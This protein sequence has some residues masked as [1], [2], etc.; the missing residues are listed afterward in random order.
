ME[1]TNTVNTRPDRVF[2]LSPNQTDQIP[3]VIVE[4]IMMNLFGKFFDKKSRTFEFRDRSTFLPKGPWVLARDVLEKKYIKNFN[5][6]HT[7]EVF[8]ELPFYISTL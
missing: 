6:H 4:V 2:S 1:L 8:R 5:T 7:I 3:E